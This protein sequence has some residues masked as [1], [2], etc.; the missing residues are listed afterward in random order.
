MRRVVRVPGVV[1]AGLRLLIEQSESLT[2]ELLSDGKLGAAAPDA[3]T[4][5]LDWL[6]D[7]LLPD[8]VKSD[9]RS[10]LPMIDVPVLILQGEFDWL[11]PPADARAAA[12]A[13]PRATYHEFDTRHLIP[14][15]KSDAVIASIF[16]FIERNAYTE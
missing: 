14:R 13:L 11:A 8:E 4:A 5:F 10:S 15:E 7:E 3:P 1:R 12:A 9:F 6:R 2:A 16:S